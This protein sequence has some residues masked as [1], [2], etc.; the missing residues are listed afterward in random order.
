[1]SG[2]ASYNM[3]E[4]I[5]NFYY[6][7]IPIS[8]GGSLYLRLLVEPSS[9][10]GGGIETDYGGYSRK[11]LP[12]DSASIFSVSPTNGRLT[13][14]VIIT[15]DTVPTGPGNGELSAFDIVDTPSG[16]FSKIYNGGPIVPTKTVVVGK[17]IKFRVG[18]LII[19][20]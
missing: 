2:W 14:G 17:A 6:R 18:A 16:A 9:R 8:I 12:R 13:N 11:E 1:M 5:L 7:G 20:F 10:S 15:M 4:E 19:T 3:A